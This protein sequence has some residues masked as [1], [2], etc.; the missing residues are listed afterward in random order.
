MNFA[1][2]TTAMIMALVNMALFFQAMK[3][4]WWI[5]EWFYHTALINAGLFNENQQPITLVHYLFG[6]FLFEQS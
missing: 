2:N 3:E 4:W 5:A 6:R 1:E